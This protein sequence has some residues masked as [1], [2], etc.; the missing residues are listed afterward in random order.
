M[1]PQFVSHYSLLMCADFIYPSPSRWPFNFCL[2][3]THVVL[4]WVFIDNHP[5]LL[6][7]IHLPCI[8]SPWSPEFVELQWSI[9]IFSDLPA[10]YEGCQNFSNWN[11]FILIQALDLFR[12]Q[13]L[14]WQT[15]FILLP[16]WVKRTKQL[17]ENEEEYKNEWIRNQI[18]YLLWNKTDFYNLMSQ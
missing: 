6:L 1:Q 3:T 7:Y 8:C 13:A 9:E 16:N 4:I 12:C 14:E 15:L 5:W 10:C 17:L 18:N 11:I 2:T